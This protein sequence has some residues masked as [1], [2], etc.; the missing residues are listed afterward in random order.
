VVGKDSLREDLA[1]TP[2][3]FR[4]R[5]LNLVEKDLVVF[6]QRYFISFDCLSKVLPARSLSIFQG[7]QML[8]T[9][10]SYLKYCPRLAQDGLVLLLHSFK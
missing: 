6:S 1:P 4:R 10:D 8:Q 9:A 7:M 5:L 3:L 2:A